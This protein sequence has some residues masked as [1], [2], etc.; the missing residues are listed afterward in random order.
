MSVSA[1]VLVTR[2]RGAL[3]AAFSD[4]VEDGMETIAKA[5]EAMA[6]L[7]ALIEEVHVT[8]KEI[9]ATVAACHQ[10]A[11]TAGAVP[12]ARRRANDAPVT[13]DPPAAGCSRA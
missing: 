10:V 13:A 6:R 9:H 7:H 2:E 4:L 12:R 1:D 11:Q 8:V 5:Q 3:R